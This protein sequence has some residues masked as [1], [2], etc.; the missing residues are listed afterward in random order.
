MG[1]QVDIA[2]ANLVNVMPL[3]KAGRLRGL[4]ITTG[5]RSSA[6]PD[7]PT[8]AESGLPGYDFAAYFGF[9]APAGVPKSIVNTLFSDI[10][11]VLNSPEIRDRLSSGGA[12]V[13]ANSPD[14]F[15][16]FLR[17]ETQKWAKVIKAAGISAE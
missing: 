3:L 13:I 15:S 17:T 4:A 5:S 16:G 2:F 9:F 7:L 10:A 12:E 6:A 14:D 8:I 11:K 1:G